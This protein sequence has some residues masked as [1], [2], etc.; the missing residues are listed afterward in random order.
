MTGNQEM[1]KCILG[2]LVSFRIYL[3]AFKS[4][5]KFFIRPT[6]F[7]IRDFKV[8]K[9]RLSVFS[10]LLS[11]SEMFLQL[12]VSG[13]AFSSSN[14]IFSCFTKI[15]IYVLMEAMP[16]FCMLHLFLSKAKKYTKQIKVSLLQ[17]LISSQV[18]EACREHMWT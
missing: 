11:S 15:H 5:S 12:M 4:I 6:R 1:L 8:T 14:G 10:H 2:L 9:K 3:W 18:P 13:Q 16:S 7:N 17:V